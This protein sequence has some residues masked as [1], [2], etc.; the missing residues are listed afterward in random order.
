MPLD[1]ERGGRGA[2]TASLHPGEHQEVRL[3]PSGLSGFVAKTRTL[4][5][6]RLR[7]K[8]RRRGRGG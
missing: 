4:G 1:R 7:D 3:D 5:E 6:R 2:D 8:L